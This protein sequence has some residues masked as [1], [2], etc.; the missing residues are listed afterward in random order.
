MLPSIAAKMV[1]K[2]IYMFI[3]I[4]MG[5]DAYFPFFFFL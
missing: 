2:Y 4:S 3:D 1:L 5:K